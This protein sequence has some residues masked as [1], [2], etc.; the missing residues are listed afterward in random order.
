VQQ[1]I[2]RAEK[3]GYKAI[4]LTVNAPWLGRREADVKNRCSSVTVFSV[5]LMN[6]PNI[7]Y[8]SGHTLPKNSVYP[9]S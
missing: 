6:L 7:Q 9:I 8:L 4:A 5:M 1:L 3:A 2:R